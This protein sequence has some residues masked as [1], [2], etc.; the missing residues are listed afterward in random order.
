MVYLLLVNGVDISPWWL[1]VER[2][3]GKMRHQ[4]QHV[5]NL[6]DFLLN[7]WRGFQDARDSGSEFAH[8]AVCRL[9]QRRFV[10]IALWYFIRALLTWFCRVSSSLSALFSHASKL[11]VLFVLL[12][13]IMFLRCDWR[14]PLPP[15]G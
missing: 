9:A 11:N 3:A 15:A 7:G 4:V 10:R 2:D 12:L 6:V 5:G 8:I 14:H 1:F 13:L